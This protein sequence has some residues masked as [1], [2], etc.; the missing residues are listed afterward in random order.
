MV[1]LK[2]MWDWM[3]VAA[4]RLKPNKKQIDILSNSQFRVAPTL[5]HV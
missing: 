1:N 2:K 4:A 5:P 3:S